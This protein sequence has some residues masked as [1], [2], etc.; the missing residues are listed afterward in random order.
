MSLIAWLEA[1]PLARSIGQ[2]LML[3]ASLSATH[4]I[5]FTM[6]MGGAVLVNLR[7]L[8]AVLA[9]LPLADVA[10]PVNRAI[11]V[12]MSISVVTGFL[13]FSARATAIVENAAF[14]LKMLML[15]VAATTHFLVQRSLLRPASKPVAVES[16][17]YRLAGTSGMLLWLGLAVAACWFILFE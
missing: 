6:V 17:R 7:L 12:G 11:M 2:S 4:L 9:S 3:T 8:G 14:Q 16:A 1:T 15:V 5:G 13:L 10:K